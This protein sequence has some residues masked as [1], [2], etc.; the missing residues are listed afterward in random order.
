MILNVADLWPDSVH[1]FGVM[2]DGSML[3][4]AERLERWSY[5]RATF[6][7]T[8]TEGIQKALVERKN[9]PHHKVLFLPNGVDTNLFRP[10]PPDSQLARQLDLEGK[11]VALYAGTHGHAHGLGVALH[12]V[13]LLENAGIV[14][15]FIG[16][17]SEKP[18]LQEMAAEMSLGNVY[19]LDPAPPEYVARLYSLA[20]IALSTLRKSSVAEETRPAKVLPAMASGKPVVYSGSGEGARLVEDT[21]A[22][23][24]V[25]PE[26][27]KALADAILTLVHNPALA[28]ELGRNGRKYVEEKLTWSALVKDW[29]RQLEAHDGVLLK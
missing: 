19:F 16:G 25:P 3:W 15:V 29:L 23:L 18:K 26:D 2:R 10:R 4:L 12:A 13:K 20:T 1:E 27:P 6:I 22:G 28:D 7:S 9:V 21:R 14:F 5:Q 8:V 11:R 24:V 17:G